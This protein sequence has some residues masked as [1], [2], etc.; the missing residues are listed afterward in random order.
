LV[1]RREEDE[2]KSVRSRC[3]LARP[4]PVAA[5]P[6]AKDAHTPR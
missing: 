2:E 6:A 3:M 5:T 1:K 4:Q